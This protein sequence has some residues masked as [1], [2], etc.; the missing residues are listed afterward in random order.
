MAW[1]SNASATSMTG[2]SASASSPKLVLAHRVACRP[3][4][5]RCKADTFGDSGHMALGELTVGR[6]L[7]GVQGRIFS[8]AHAVWSVSRQAR[9][10]LHLGMV[11]FTS[12]VSSTS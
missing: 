6:L 9:K 4:L 8:R 5:G 7:G 2:T 12:S 3:S 10:P 1:A 11:G